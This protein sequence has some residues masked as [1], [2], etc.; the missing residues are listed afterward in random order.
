MTR[1]VTRHATSDDVD[2]LVAIINRA[3]RIEDFFVFGDRVAGNDI[4][5]KMSQGVFLVIDDDSSPGEVRLASAVYV[6]VT[7]D[8]GYFGPLAVDPACQGR[9]LGKAMVAAAES[10]CRARGCRYMDIDVVNLRT[11]LPPFYE[12]L[13]Y[14]TTGMKEFPTPERLRRPAHVVLMT[15]PI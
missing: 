9:G 2:A 14:V 5:E 7:G 6:R 1:K 11:E 12:S 8:R 15:K 3:Y 4:V 10:H 13:G